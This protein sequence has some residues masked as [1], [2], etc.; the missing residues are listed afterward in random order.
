MSTLGRPGLD[1]AD[2]ASIAAAMAA[3]APGHRDQRLGLYGR[4]P[5]ETELDAAFAV[6]ATGPRLLAMETP[7][8]A[9]FPFIHVSTDYVFDGSRQSAPM[10]GRRSRQPARRLC[11]VS[12]LEGENAI[13][14]ATDAL[15]HRP[16]RPGCY[17][18]HGQPISCAPCCGWGRSA[19]RYAIVARPATG[20][21]TAAK[22]LA[23]ASSRS[24]SRLAAPRHFGTY[25]YCGKGDGD[26][27]RL[28]RGDLRADAFCA[29]ASRT[30]ERLNAI[31]T[32][33]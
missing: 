12:K 6:N 13:R 8:A 23:R 24:L 5:R 10:A 18:A 31:T 25:H 30:P 33:D 22:D 7:D 14:A 21:P 20:C 29:G 27:V 32:A 2:A 26:L 9:A 3:Q 15:R 4:G 11:Q 16:H 17:A 19:T 28:R 1:M